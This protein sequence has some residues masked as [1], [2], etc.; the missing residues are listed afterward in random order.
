M[1]LNERSETAVACG[2]ILT[3]GA[4]WF[5]LGQQ[6]RVSAG[7]VGELQTSV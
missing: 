3:F 4:R 5:R 6:A 7:A 1:A 2:E